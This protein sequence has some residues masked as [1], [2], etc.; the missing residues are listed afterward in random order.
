MKIFVLINEQDTDAINQSTVDLFLDKEA[1][2]AEMH[3]QF[4]EAFQVWGLDIDHL[5]DEQ[6]CEC[7]QDAAVIRDDIDSIN[8]RIEEKELDVQVAIRVHGGL[9]QAVYANADMSPDVYDL[10]V[11]DYPDEDELESA[12][13]REEGLNDLVKSPGWRSV[14]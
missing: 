1:A 4:E 9:V 6:E 11:S 8:W 12:Q 7:G 10:D 5:C 13:K 2:R 14:W 3:K